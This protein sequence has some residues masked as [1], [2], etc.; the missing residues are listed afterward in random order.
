M[1]LREMARWGRGGIAQSI[2]LLATLRVQERSGEI[3][4]MRN[5]NRLLHT[6]RLGTSPALNVV[7][8]FKD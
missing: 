3:Q 5:F 1:A 7:T 8:N 4:D 6:A 2:V